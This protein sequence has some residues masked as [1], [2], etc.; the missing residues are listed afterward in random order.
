[1]KILFWLLFFLFVG[2]VML[3][4]R[5]VPKGVF[6]NKAPIEFERQKIRWL[7]AY[8]SIAVL[9]F[10]AGN[11]RGIVDYFVEFVRR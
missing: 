8:A 3:K 4:K 10:L 2:L 1:M 9:I 5:P 7:A 6:F 11:M